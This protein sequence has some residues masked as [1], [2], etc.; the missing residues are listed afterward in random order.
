MVKI[1][2]QRTGRRHRSSFRIVA[3]DIRQSRDGKVIEN[4]GSYNP[5]AKVE[6]AQIQVDAERVAHWLSVGAQ[7]T[8]TVAQLLKKKGIDATPGRAAEKKVEA[9]AAKPAE[10]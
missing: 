5:E 4:L 1:R 2:L 9:K 7:P 6:D 8:E 10:E 3:C